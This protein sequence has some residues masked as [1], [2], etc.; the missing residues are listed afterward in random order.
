MK[1]RLLSLAVACLLL[2]SALCGCGSRSTP[3]ELYEIYDEAV[4]LIEASFAINDALLGHG[5]PV[6]EIGSEYAELNKLYGADDFANYEHVTPETPYREIDD[7]K[8]AMAA[9]YSTDYCQS[10]YANL[11]DGFVSGSTLVRAQYREDS[12]GLYLTT[13]YEPLVTKQRIYDYATMKIVEPSSLD[14]VNLEIES[15]LPGET[16]R[17][18]V[19]ISLVLEED[20]WRLDT[21]TY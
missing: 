15:Y 4:A 12:E 3:P 7:I 8:A 5:L 20:G 16:E 11:F 6:Y 13:D 2:L 1:Q 18:S 17:M 14:Y 10:L 9:V 21:P 19:T